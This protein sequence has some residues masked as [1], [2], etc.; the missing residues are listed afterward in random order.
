MIIVPL[1]VLLVGGGAATWWLWTLAQDHRGK[2]RYAAFL[3]TGSERIMVRTPDEAFENL[4]DFPF[5]PQYVVVDG[6]R[7]H[8]IDEGPPEAPP[9]LLLH[10]EPTWSYLYRHMIPPLAAAGYRVVA[11]DLIGFG[12]SDKLVHQADY[13]YQMHV[14]MMQ[15]F[16]E[17]LD[18][19]DITLFCQ[20]WGGLIGLRVA[21]QDPGR[22]ARIAAGNTAL[23]G[24]TPEG[25]YEPAT[26]RPEPAPKPLR[27]FLGWLLYSQ[28]TPDLHAG[29]VV[30]MGTV[31]RIAP[32]IKAA[33][34]APYPAAEYKAGM[35]KFPRIVMSQWE[36]NTE[37]WEQLAQWQQ[38]FL[39]LFSDGDPIMRGGERVFQRVIPGA[40]GQPHTVIE[41]AGHFLQEDQG[42]L[43]AE[44]LI[45]F[46]EATPGF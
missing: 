32:E 42:P 25:P 8:Y 31:N 4:P 29:D 39:T 34:N 22:F 20:D 33:Y 1:L 46:M 14:D 11:P 27:A 3:E 44:K 10:G 36:E 35:R 30:Q 12:R 40:Q 6:L 24:K 17:A 43:L 23:P 9:V 41:G 7:M 13:S 45:Q 15:G 21:V 26:P 18:L 5:E 16:I 38:P 37:A 19:R 28:L 2:A